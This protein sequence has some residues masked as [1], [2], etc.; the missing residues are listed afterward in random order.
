[1]PMSD[2][3]K[4]L[5]PVALVGIQRVLCATPHKGCLQTDYTKLISLERVHQ[6]LIPIDMLLASDEAELDPL[7]GG[8]EGMPDKQTSLRL[9]PPVKRAG[10]AGMSGR[11]ASALAVVGSQDGRCKHL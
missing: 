1:M 11:H 6:K 7:P 2:R 3:R 8:G 9:P 4:Q 10:H 5:L